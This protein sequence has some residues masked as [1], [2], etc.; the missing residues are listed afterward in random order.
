MSVN[1]KSLRRPTPTTLPQ[2]G[3]V[4]NVSA[5]RTPELVLAFVGAAGSGVTGV[6]KA[7]EKA[8]SEKF[9]YTSNVVKV[10]D[11]IAP[12]GAALGKPIDASLSRAERIERL[13]D[14]G[15]SL[16]KNQSSD[17]LMKLCIERIAKWRVEK[18]GYHG[19]AGGLGAALPKRWV[20]IVDEIKHPDEARLLRD[21][22]GDLF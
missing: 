11:L 17:H 12:F 8:L 16:R 14:I 2:G 20:H 4:L 10:S 1:V 19:G 15:N 3:S 5:R 9:G 22:Y 18:D 13:Q 7:F 21:V 6:A